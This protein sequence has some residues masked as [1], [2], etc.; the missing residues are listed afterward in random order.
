MK[1]LSKEPVYTGSEIMLAL[2]YSFCPGC[3][4]SCD[5]WLP[6]VKLS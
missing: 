4:K 6:W 2:E 1:P 5:R 3:W